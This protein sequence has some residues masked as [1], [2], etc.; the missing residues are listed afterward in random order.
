MS[1]GLFIS[2]Y[3]PNKTAYDKSLLG[4]ILLSGTLSS[5]TCMYQLICKL[6]FNWTSCRM[7]FEIYENR[8]LKLKI[9]KYLLA[10][11][12][13]CN[14][15]KSLTNIYYHVRYWPILWNEFSISSTKIA[16]FH[17]ISYKCY[18]VQEIPILEKLY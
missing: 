7:R 14:L 13:R 8:F 16:R 15:N 3:L 10:D 11:F 9:P 17:Q 2:A 1:C 4:G 5:L 12:R 18:N 6:R